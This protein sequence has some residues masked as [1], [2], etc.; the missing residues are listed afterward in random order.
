M[1]R[2]ALGA[3]SALCLPF[4]LSAQNVA[5]QKAGYGAFNFPNRGSIDV[6]AP[7][8]SI[9]L[10]GVQKIGALYYVTG[11][12]NGSTQ[13]PPHTVYVINGAGTLVRQFPQDSATSTSTWG[14]RDMATDGTVLMAGYEGGVHVINPTTGA[15]V[16]TIKAKNGNQTITANPIVIGTGGPT[17]YRGLAYDPDGNGGKGSLWTGN[18]G[19]DLIEFDLSGTVL[20]RYAATTNSP[21]WSIYGLAWDPGRKTLWCNSAP[22]QGPLAEIDPATGKFTGQT[23]NRAQ[24][25]TAQ[26]GLCA[27]PD[28]NGGLSL[29]GLDQGAP[30]AITSYRVHRTGTFDGWTE[31]RMT[32]AVSP[33]ALNDLGPKIFVQTPQNIQFGYDL[34]GDATLT[35]RPGLLFINAGPGA[36]GEG[37]TPTFTELVA[38]WPLSTPPDAGVILLPTTLSAAAVPLTIPSIPGIM[39]GDRIRM[40]TVYF[41][42]KSPISW[43]ETNQVLWEFS[44]QTIVIRAQGSNSFNS[45]ASFG[46]FSVQNRG[47]AGIEELTFSWVNSSNTGQ[48]TMRFDTNQTGMAD[49]FDGGNSTT[50]GCLG[51]YRNNCDVSCGL[52]Y[53]MMNNITPTCDASANSGVIGSDAGTAAGD[54][55]TLKWRFK[56]QTFNL[57]KTFEFDCDTDGGV[58]TNGSS[59]DGLIVTI[60]LIGNRT[61]TGE[62]RAVQGNANL[63]RLSFK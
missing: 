16:N 49:R 7:T 36:Q 47:A 12:G 46:F 21:A 58:G 1:Q 24:P 19:N 59:M 29:I 3:L 52:I 28:A 39:V 27:V 22:N 62:L 23:V 38:K 4:A 50:T 54:Y 17:V 11:R 35:G 32:N 10:L 20:R 37:R 2:I 8:S 30:D 61:V 55:R 41:E 57:G 34:S 31:A 9:Q 26:G 5:D 33:G 15:K 48:G 40:Q 6:E 18:F 45:N 42:P 51:T 13:T 56:P 25:G 44:D 14:W 43:V 53:D 63:S 60:K